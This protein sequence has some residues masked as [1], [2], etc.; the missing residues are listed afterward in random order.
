MIILAYFTIGV[1]YY[2][3]APDHKPDNTFP[4]LYELLYLIFSVVGWPYFLFQ[5]IR[6]KLIVWGIWCIAYYFQ[7]KLWLIKK[8]RK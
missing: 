7:I 4:V 5:Y 1:I 8:L 2:L 6:P 3:F